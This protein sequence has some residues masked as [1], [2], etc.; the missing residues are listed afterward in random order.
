M[1]KNVSYETWLGKIA[2]TR[3]VAAPHVDP[4]KP[5]FFLRYRTGTESAQFSTNMEHGFESF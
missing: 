2:G 3:M 4:T 5:A 1:T